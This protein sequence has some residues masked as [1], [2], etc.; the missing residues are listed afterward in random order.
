MIQDLRNENELIRKGHGSKLGDQKLMEEIT[1]RERE[2]IEISGH[3]E[4][5]RMNYEA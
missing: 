4:E 2:I 3:M 5:V 1:R